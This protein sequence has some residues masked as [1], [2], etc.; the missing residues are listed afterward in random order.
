MVPRLWRVSECELRRSRRTQCGLRTFRRAAIGGQGDL[1]RFSILVS[2]TPGGPL[3]DE[4]ARDV[5]LATHVNV[6]TGPVWRRIEHFT[7]Y[8]V[9]TGMVDDCTPG[10]DEGCYAIGIIIRDGTP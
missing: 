2:E 9:Y 5:T 1:R 10:I 7:G 6:R 4:S 3:V 8:N